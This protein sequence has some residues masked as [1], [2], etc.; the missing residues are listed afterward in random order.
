MEEVNVDHRFKPVMQHQPLLLPPDV[1][2]LIAP[3]ALVRVIDQLVDHVDRDL[4]DR[5]YPGGGAPAYD[6][7]MMLKVVLYSY[8]SGIYS[9]RD[10]AKA[11]RQDLH[12]M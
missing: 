12:A 1:C 4:L 3:D 10:I 5:L 11:T 9:S 2:D 7:V 8:A 6:P